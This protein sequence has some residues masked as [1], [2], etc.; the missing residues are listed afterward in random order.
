MKV[1]LISVI[2]PCFN[3]GAF[4]KD[5]LISLEQCDKNLFEIIIVNDGSTDEFTNR[6]LK[7]LSDGGIFVL[8]QE[9]MGLARARNNGIKKATGKY[10]LPLDSDNKIRPEYLTEGIDALEKD[11]SVAVVYGNASYFGSK[12]G[13]L[14]PGKFNLQRLMLRNFID[15]CAVI[16]KSVI[17]EVGYYDTMKFM[18]LEDWDLWLRIAFAGHKF[19]YVDKVLFDYRVSAKSMIKD[20]TGSVEKQN[21]IE[22]YFLAKYSDKLSPDDVLDDVMNRFKGKPFRFLRKIFLRKY[23][24]TYYKKLIES[25][26]IY[27]SDF[28]D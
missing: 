15:A 25:N 14:K 23:F 7:E 19:Y 5:A 22:E 16:R 20:L 1:S 28:Y 3:Q 13:L 4:I 11:E 24:P 6:Y 10:I 26:K 2:I 27:S 21:R 9:N 8:F 18:G 12:N 17:E